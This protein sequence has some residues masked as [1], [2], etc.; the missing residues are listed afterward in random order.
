MTVEYKLTQHQGIPLKFITEKVMTRIEAELLYARWCKLYPWEEIIVTRTT[1]SRIGIVSTGIT[2]RTE[3]KIIS[4]EF[5]PIADAVAK[6][7]KI[8]GF[9]GNADCIVCRPKTIMPEKHT[10]SKK[11]TEG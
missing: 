10:D 7:L 3:H 1:I 8:E 9:C 11:D 2:N 6:C 4:K 5:H